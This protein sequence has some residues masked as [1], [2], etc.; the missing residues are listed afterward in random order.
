MIPLFS[1]ETTVQIDRYLIDKK[2]I[3]GSVLM[4]NAGRGVYEFI[5]ERGLDISN[6]VIVSGKGNNGGD[7][8]VVGRYLAGKGSVTVFYTGEEYKGESGLFFNVLKNIPRIDLI[9][10]RENNLNELKERI[11]DSTLVIDALFGT[12]FKGEVRGFY[13]D[14][15]N[16][17]N[18]AKTILSVDIPS[19]W[20]AK[21]G[22]SGIGIEADYVVTMMTYKM[23]TFIPFGIKKKMEIKRVNIGYPEELLPVFEESAYLLEDEDLEWTGSSRFDV[24]YKNQRG[25]LAVIGGADKYPGSVTI[26]C[27]AAL[28]TAGNMVFLMSSDYTS[29][30]CLNRY[31]EVMKLSV[32]FPMRVGVVEN[33]I[34]SMRIDTVI[35][36][37]GWDIGKDRE[38]VLLYLINE[39]KNKGLNILIDADGLKV[40][41]KIRDRVN[42][43]LFDNVLL[44]PHT[45][46]LSI[47]IDKDIEFVIN[48]K[49]ETLKIFNEYYGNATLLWKGQ[50]ALIY[51][52]G[53][54]YIYNMPNS[55]LSKPGSGDM[56]AGICGAILSSC[57]D[58][59]DAAISGMIIQGIAGRIISEKLGTRSMLPSDVI[60]EIPNVVKGGDYE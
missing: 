26:T 46:E 37:N 18:E 14:V 6:V 4:E 10:L 1:A 33:Y 40:L 48:N 55:G 49:E 28:R 30:I 44:T 20:N 5:K 42:K 23:G 22:R 38:E 27:G 53:K 15:I 57:K 29:N 25:R 11:K 52:K 54:I 7:G 60:E 41:S 31:P 16:I 47:L 12:G 19:G 17:M 36:G 51:K 3:D 56:L 58:P 8:F 39:S 45:G 50:G 2:G 32:D 34:N 59:L 21:W 9:P 43:N 35:V 24:E 13:K